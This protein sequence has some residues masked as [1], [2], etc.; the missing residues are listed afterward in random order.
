MVSITKGMSEVDVIGSTES[1]YWV[2]S[3]GLLSNK[4]VTIR[5]HPT[6]DTIQALN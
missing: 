3:A 1:R 5:T 4:A 2:T 6:F